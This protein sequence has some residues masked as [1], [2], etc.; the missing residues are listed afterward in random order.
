M[1][2]KFRQIEA[3]H[4]KKQSRLLLHKNGAQ[5]P[6]AVGYWAAAHP[7][8]VFSL[9]NELK[10]DG[11]RRFLDLGSG[12]G[13][14]V[15]VASLFTSAVG[16]EFD[17]ALHNEAV[18]MRDA[19][20]L[21]MELKKCDFLEED[22]SAYDFIFINPD[23][24]FYRLEGKLKKEFKGTLV[25]GGELYKPLLLKPEK[26]MSAKGIDYSIYRLR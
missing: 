9:F 12:D 25:V 2:D 20:G 6:T 11:Y 23:D 3:Y 21:S 17:D 26:K 5:R 7:G 19:L 16:V 15:A 8:S 1:D 14:V 13:V 10:L 4:D 18:S 22:F 24:H